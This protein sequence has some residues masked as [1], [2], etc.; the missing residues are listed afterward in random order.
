MQEPNESILEIDLNILEEEWVNQPKLYFRFASQL[1]DA[2]R[3]EGEAKNQIEVT[4]A[5]LDLA[6]RTNPEKFDQPEK[7]GKCKPTEKSIA[8]AI[9]GDEDYEKSFTAHL[10]AKHAVDI[11][12]A[13][14]I[15]LEHRKKALEKAVDLHGQ[16][17]WA[18]PYT[19]N[20]K[21]TTEDFEKHTARRKKKK[22]RHHD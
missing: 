4:K 18:K 6:I 2:R 14:T 21:E 16:N 7:D 20:E 3:E 8:A 19:K 5:E 13:M 22:R 17:Y 1:A 15:A 10:N 9:I 11:L 12:Q